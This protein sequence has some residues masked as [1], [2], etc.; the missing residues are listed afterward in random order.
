MWRIILSQKTYNTEV[1]VLARYVYAKINE[2][3]QREKK[4]IAKV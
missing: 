3:E 4:A 1:R 2:V